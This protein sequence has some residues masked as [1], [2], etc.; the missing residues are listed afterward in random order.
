MVRG[1]AES[2]FMQCV[3]PNHTS[4]TVSVIPWAFE[5][6]HG[7]RVHCRAAI[8]SHR[9]ASR[10]YGQR[11]LVRQHLR[12]S[13][14]PIAGVLADNSKSRFGRRRPYMI[15]GAIIT[16]VATILFGFTRPVA[17]IFSEEG[18]GLVST[19]EVRPICDNSLIMC[20]VQGYVNLVSH[21]CHL[22]HGL[23]NKCRHVSWGAELFLPL[24]LPLAT[25]SSSCRPSLDR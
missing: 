18:S 3:Y 16:A 11:S 17:G 19:S 2:S 22:R 12:S 5:I 20:A 21:T 1:Q 14:L 15:G 13:Q 25:N 4:L 24:K 9:S 7:H 6:P 23:L 8:R 10:R